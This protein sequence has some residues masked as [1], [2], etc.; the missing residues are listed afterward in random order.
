MTAPR[1]NIEELAWAREVVACEVVADDQL[2]RACR[3]I[4]ALSDQP[5]EVARARDLLH[6]IDGERVR[7]A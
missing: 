1:A 2:A 3:R 5:R 4:V 6:L 7:A